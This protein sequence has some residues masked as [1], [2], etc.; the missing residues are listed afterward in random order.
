M[1]TTA[2]LQQFAQKFAPKRTEEEKKNT[3]ETIKK[4][5]NETILWHDCYWNTNIKHKLF[6]I[7]NEAKCAELQKEILNYWSSKSPFRVCYNEHFK[8]QHQNKLNSNDSNN[9]NNIPNYCDIVHIL[10]D[11][12]SSTQRRPLFLKL[13]LYAIECQTFNHEKENQMQ[14][15]TKFTSQIKEHQKEI[16]AIMNGK[17]EEESKDN[18]D[19]DKDKDKKNKDKDKNKKS[20]LT[21][22]EKAI[23]EEKKKKKLIIS[24][25]E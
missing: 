5:Q 9:N 11:H 16:D 15:R 24:T 8:W 14:V 10:G 25:K 12:L 21:P 1:A 18:K 13:L 6:K 7:D 23:I 19:K 20:Q 4:M 2:T 17:K 3:E 22:N